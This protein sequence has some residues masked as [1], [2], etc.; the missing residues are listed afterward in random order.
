MLL[1]RKTLSKFGSTVREVV[2]LKGCLQG[3]VLS[4]LLWSVMTDSF[5]KRIVQ[6]GVCINRPICNE[7]KKTN[8]IVV[9]N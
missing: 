4:L 2:S 6:D 8:M 9:R 5:L 7:A 3:E 1:Y